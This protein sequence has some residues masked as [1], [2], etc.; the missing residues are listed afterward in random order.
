[1]PSRFGFVLGLHSQDP[2]TIY[3]IPEDA[4]LGEDAGGGQRCVSD[5]KFRVF[6][7]QNGGGDWEPLPNGLPERNAYLHCMRE[8]MATDGIDDCGVYVSG[9][10]PDRSSTAATTAT[11]GS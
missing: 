10:R 5:A 2:D 4:A 8:G 11:P 1:M 7:S 9:R 3:V 6:R